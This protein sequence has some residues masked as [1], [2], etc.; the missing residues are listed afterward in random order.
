MLEWDVLKS[1]VMANGVLYV[2]TVDLMIMLLRLSVLSWVTMI[3]I[4][5]VLLHS[6]CL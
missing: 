1:I 6:E 5:P 2:M 4:V 3:S